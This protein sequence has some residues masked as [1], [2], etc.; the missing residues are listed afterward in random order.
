MVVLP[1]STLNSA[2]EIAQCLCDCIAAQIDNNR[3]LLPASVAL[4]RQCR[5]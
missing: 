5:C 2:V 1:D 4:T 3:W